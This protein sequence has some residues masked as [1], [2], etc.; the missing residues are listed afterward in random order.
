[1]EE[2]FQYGQYGFNFSPIDGGNEDLVAFGVERRCK[3]AN[4]RYAVKV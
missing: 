2:H 3:G 4:S 1:M